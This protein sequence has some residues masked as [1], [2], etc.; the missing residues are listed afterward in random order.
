MKCTF[1]LVLCR[2][3][4]REVYIALR[5]T[6]RISLLRLAWKIRMFLVTV[7]MYQSKPRGDALPYAPLTAAENLLCGKSRRTS[8]SIDFVHYQY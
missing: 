7:S 8:F 2:T 5:R 1:H 3:D 6:L 4:I